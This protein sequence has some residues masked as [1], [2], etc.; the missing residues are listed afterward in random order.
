MELAPQ[1]LRTLGRAQTIR[2]TDQMVLTLP[3]SF[4]LAVA[5]APQWIGRIVSWL[6]LAAFVIAVAWSYLSN[7]QPGPYGQCYASRGHPIPCELVKKP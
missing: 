5:G 7:P 3:R 1:L 4:S 6:L 2:S